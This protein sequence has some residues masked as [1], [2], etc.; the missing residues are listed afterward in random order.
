MLVSSDYRVA[1]F[2]C[3]LYRR[4]EEFRYVKFFVYTVAK[5]GRLRRSR[6]GSRHTETLLL[7]QKAAQPGVLLLRISLAGHSVRR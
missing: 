3:F 5:A 4:A 7:R 1:S 2:A 6:L